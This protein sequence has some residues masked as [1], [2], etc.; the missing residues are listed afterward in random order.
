M[1]TWGISALLLFLPGPA[2]FRP[3][4]ESYADGL[5][6]SQAKELAVYVLGAV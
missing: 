1:S 5:W 2:L 6:V 4:Y 3:E